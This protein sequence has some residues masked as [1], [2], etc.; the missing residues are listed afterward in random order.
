VV[1]ARTTD[2]CPCIVSVGGA[3]RSRLAQRGAGRRAGVV[4][5]I[6]GITGGR[7]V[8]AEV[9]ILGHRVL[10][11]PAPATVGSSGLKTGAFRHLGGGQSSP[12]SEAWR[13]A[14]AD[15]RAI[16]HLHTTAQKA[17]AVKGVVR[18]LTRATARVQSGTEWLPWTMTGQVTVSVDCR[19]TMA[20]TVVH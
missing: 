4:L 16:L 15:R 12:P 1:W 3:S 2:R 9:A 7:R 14:R 5:G 18:A 11:G 10:G 20:A 8:L 19:L 6:T 13:E 17:A